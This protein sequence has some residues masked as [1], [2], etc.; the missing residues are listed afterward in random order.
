M[1]LHQ[2]EVKPRTSINNNV[3]A[4]PLV[5]TLQC[6][7]GKRDNNDNKD[8]LWLLRYSRLISHLKLSN[9]LSWTC[10]ISNCWHAINFI[11][12]AN[13]G[14]NTL[15]YN[16]LVNT[17]LYNKLVVLPRQLLN[18]KFLASLENNYIQI[19]LWWREEIEICHLWFTLK[20]NTKVSYL[21][22]L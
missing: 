3:Q 8:I 16:N 15:L 11:K 17:L 22:L 4:Q 21:L 12:V 5:Y 10:L 2:S 6:Q 18:S 7:T 13:V 1:W 14:F 20:W 9:T 19:L